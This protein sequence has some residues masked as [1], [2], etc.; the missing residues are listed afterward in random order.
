MGR[1][2]VAPSGALALAKSSAVL[3]KASISS[4]APSR[5]TFPAD[6]HRWARFLRDHYNGDLRL[7]MWNLDCSERQA[8]DWLAGKNSPRVETVLALVQREPHVL[9]LLLGAA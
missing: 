8:R 3:A 1:S 2:L 5:G 7:I 9:P 4:P 6:L